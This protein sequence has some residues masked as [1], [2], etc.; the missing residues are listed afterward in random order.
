MVLMLNNIL[1][2]VEGHTSV[3][4]SFVKMQLKCLQKCTHMNEYVQLLQL[5]VVD[6]VLT[7]EQIKPY[8]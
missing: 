3:I 6:Q 5:N 4:A 2:Q 1:F 8:W 7:E